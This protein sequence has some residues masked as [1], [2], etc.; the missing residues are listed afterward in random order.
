MIVHCIGLKS[1]SIDFPNYNTK[2]FELL[3][4]FFRS[5]RKLKKLNHLAI[6]FHYSITDHYEYLNVIK[7]LE[8]LCVV[9]PKSKKQGWTRR[10]EF[11]GEVTFISP[12][13][14]KEIR[15]SILDQFPDNPNLIIGV[16]LD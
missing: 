14:I 7:S 15:R 2:Q 1:L 9:I 10:D 16:L 6:P 12:L 5:F 4:A 13:K 8:I 3:N 11:W